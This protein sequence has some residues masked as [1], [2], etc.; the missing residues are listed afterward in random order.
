MGKREKMGEIDYYE[1]LDEAV[2]RARIEG[3]H[4]E[5]AA[6]REILRRAETAARPAGEV[7]ASAVADY[8]TGPRKA[9]IESFDDTDGERCLMAAGIY[10]TT[11]RASGECWATIAHEAHEYLR[12]SGQHGVGCLRTLVALSPRG[13]TLRE[14]WAKWAK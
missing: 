3:L 2:D 8:Q 7:E 13:S 6:L 9:I 14:W 1:K 12:A 11:G 5:R 10:H 4:E